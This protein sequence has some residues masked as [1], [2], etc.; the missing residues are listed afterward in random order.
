MKQYGYYL[1]ETKN[2]EERWNTCVREAI[3]IRI[4][5]VNEVVWQTYEKEKEQIQE[6]FFRCAAEA[7][8]QMPKLMESGHKGPIRYIH[9]SYLLSGALSGEMLLKMDCYDEK[10][11]SDIRDVNCYWDYSCLYPE[12]TEAAAKLEE[13]LFMEIPRLSVP[14]Q[15]R[16]R[17][18][19]QVSNIMALEE[20]IQSLVKS[21]E[22]KSC[23]Q[24]YAKP[25]VSIFFGAYLDQAELIHE[26]GGD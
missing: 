9:F 15:Q 10:Y 11:F 8:K 4:K 23:I 7:M 17:L 26:L 25:V 5:T 1:G 22:F 14:E 21:D 3:E 13:K 12:Y 6:S 20:I 2:R 18:Y 24:V 16:A 19:Y